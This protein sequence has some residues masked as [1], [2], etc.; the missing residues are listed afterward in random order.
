MKTEERNLVR[1]MA[2]QLK[3]S[4]ITIRELL[5]IAVKHKPDIVPFLRQIYDMNDIKMTQAYES[6]NNGK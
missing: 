3:F 4:N 2:E 1:D 5:H 6:L